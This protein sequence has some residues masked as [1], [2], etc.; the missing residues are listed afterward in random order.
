MNI[1]ISQYPDTDD[2]ERRM[3]GFTGEPEPE[4]QAAATAPLPLETQRFNC[5]RSM[6]LDDTY[7]L[8]SMLANET[9]TE[10]ECRGLKSAI[11]H[12]ANIAIGGV[13]YNGRAAMLCALLNEIPQPESVAIASHLKPLIYEAGLE[14][15]NSAIWDVPGTRD[16]HMEEIIRRA[17]SDKP[18]WLVVGDIPQYRSA[19][20]FAELAANRKGVLTT[21]ASADTNHLLEV[22]SVEALQAET[23]RSRAARRE[24]N[25]IQLLRNSIDMVIILGYSQNRNIKIL[26]LFH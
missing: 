7:T 20:L 2:R 8:H 17:E 14:Y 6:L 4:Q 11:A 5:R 10:R 22:L 16:S 21:I 1:A 12:K 24:V 18:D 19:W 26:D 9:I 15:G 25:Y 23:E 13:P 3:R